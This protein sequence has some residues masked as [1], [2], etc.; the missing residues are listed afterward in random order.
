MRLG[1]IGFDAVAGYLDD[2]LACLAD[3]PELTSTTERLSPLL[4]AER[5]AGGTLIVDVRAPTER[6]A[7]AIPGSL[8]L[9][10][11]QLS[12][13][14][15]ELPRDRPLLVHCAGGY[16]SSIAASVLKAEGFPDVTELAGGIAAWEQAGQPVTAREA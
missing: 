14:L 3:R 1:R 16:R 10:L 15:N 13:R 12:R 4:A 9:P 7:G 2:G 8:S 11:S 5:A 6:S